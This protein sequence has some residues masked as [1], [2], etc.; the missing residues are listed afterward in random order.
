MATQIHD[1]RAVSAASLATW[2]DQCQK[3]VL[4]QVIQNAIIKNGIQAVAQNRRRM[5]ELPLSFSHEIAT[6]PITNQKQ[7][8]RCWIFAGLNVV[9]S[10]M[11][12]SLHLKALELSQAYLMFYDKLEK[13]NYFLESILKT[14]AEPH[15]GRLVSWLLMAPLQD[16]GQW[17]MFVNL[18]DKYG[19]VPIQAMPE[20]FHSS[21]SRHMNQ[22]MTGKLREDAMRL[23]KAVRDGMPSESLNALKDHMMSDVYRMLT[24]F[25]GE[26]PT[27]LD[28]EYKDDDDQFH[29]HRGMSPQELFDR[30]AGVDLH[31]YVS[32]INAPTEDKPF[33]ETYTVDYLGNVLDGHSVLYLNLPIDEFRML[34]QQQIVEGQPVWFGCDVGKFSERVSGVL[35]S[36]QFDYAAALGVDFHFDKAMRL[37]F[38]ESQMDH[39][40]V[41]TGVN[42]VD[43]TPNRWKVENSWGSDAGK[44]G[45]FVMSDAWFS[46]YM[47]QVVVKKSYLNE[48]QQQALA[49]P[50]HH[51]PPWDP[52]GSLAVR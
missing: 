13:A 19:V 47:Y 50:P 38:G 20:S 21:N 49:K 45:F 46:E 10:H 1:T 17:D 9:R 23:R 6:G 44:D 34:A 32:V 43:G 39:A 41:L 18:V 8:G 7:S 52:M 36:E 11:A 31:Q 12:K 35:D 30:Y 26:P 25:L 2:R 42:V 22:I 37:Q 3:D 15:D 29:A 28:V 14:A 27:V 51:L 4:H 24:H 40:M 48:D 5:T 33:Y 16:G